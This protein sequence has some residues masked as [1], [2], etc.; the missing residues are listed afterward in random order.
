MSKAF[1]LLRAIEEVHNGTEEVNRIVEDL[2]FISMAAYKYLVIICDLHRLSPSEAYVF[3][4]C[5]GI[6][7]EET[8]SEIAIKKAYRILLEKKLVKKPSLGVYVVNP[9]LWNDNIR[10]AEEVNLTITST[11]LLISCNEN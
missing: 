7:T 10:T 11:N 4:D 2:E 3:L 9:Y 1:T 5:C 8:Y 6:K